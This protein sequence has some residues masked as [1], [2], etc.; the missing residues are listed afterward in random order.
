MEEIKLNVKGK[1]LEVNK[2]AIEDS[3]NFFEGVSEAGVKESLENLSKINQ[4]DLDNMSMI[5]FTRGKKL[6]LEVTVED[7]Y[8]SSLLFKW[9]HNQS[10]P[11]LMGCSL[12]SIHF[13]MPSEFTEEEKRA[14]RELYKRVIGE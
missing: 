3:I 2:K 10:R 8:M 13:S 4:E 5:Y 14:I 11:H 12:D 9:L 7:S 6:W 1:V